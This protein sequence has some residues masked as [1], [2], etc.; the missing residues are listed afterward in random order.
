MQPFQLL[1]VLRKEKDAVQTLIMHLEI[2]DKHI[3]LPVEGRLLPGVEG[4]HFC[5]VIR[6][7]RT[8]HLYHGPAMQLPQQFI[9][10]LK[11]LYPHPCLF[12]ALRF[13]SFRRSM[14]LFAVKKQGKVLLL[15]QQGL[16]KNFDP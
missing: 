3:K 16:V 4:N 2:V 7:R 5:C 6:S 8:S 11:V 1:G 12:L 9:R 14:I 13:F 15:V 10:F